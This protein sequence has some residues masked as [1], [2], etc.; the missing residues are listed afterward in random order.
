MPNTQT[1]MLKSGLLG[2]LLLATYTLTAF[3]FFQ[4]KATPHP[5]PTPYIRVVLPLSATTVLPLFT[6]DANRHIPELLDDLRSL[7]F[8]DFPDEY[9]LWDES[10]INPYGVRLA[11]MTDTIKIDLRGYTP[12]TPKYVTSDFGFR[13]GSFHYGIDLKVHKGDTVWCAFDGQVRLIGYQRR[14]YGNYIVVRHHNGLE[15]LYGHLEK[16]FVASGQMVSSGEALGLGGTTG[17]SFGYHLHFETRYIGNV[18][19]PNDLIDFKQLRVT[20]EVFILSA[21]NFEYVK[22]V[23]KVRFWTVKSGD[24]LGKISSRT[25]V[26]IT[27]LCTL[28]NIKKTSILRIGQKIR[29]T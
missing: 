6:P 28:N 8:D 12:P 25:G 17:R 13:K 3:P 5:T 9:E 27:R 23:E 11:G 18:I 20:D 15:T 24:S 4:R 22:E 10:L 21:D 29:Y 19:N 1:L 26:S 14:G 7:R 16:V 2:I